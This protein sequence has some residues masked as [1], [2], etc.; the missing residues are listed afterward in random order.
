V[1]SKFSAIYN[2][3][4][5]FLGFGFAGKLIMYSDYRKEMVM[6]ITPQITFKN[7]PE[8]PALVEAVLNRVDHL[9]RMFPRVLACRVL[10]ETPHHRHHKGN[11]FQIRI[12]LSVPGK[13]IVVNREPGK[14]L[15]HTDVYVAIRDAFNAADRRLKNYAR[16]LRGE[17]KSHE[18]QNKTKKPLDQM[19]LEVAV[20]DDLLWV[21]SQ[22]T[23]STIDSPAPAA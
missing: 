14:N 8:S 3:P 21:S 7:T 13:E 4:T 5:L 2:A 16:E 9:E 22:G 11:I 15:A 12:S 10:I 18:S 23:E 6:K 17:V 20:E 19:P 1:F